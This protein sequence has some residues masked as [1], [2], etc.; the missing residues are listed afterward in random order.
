MIKDMVG[1]ARQHACNDIQHLHDLA[2]A[3]AA[4]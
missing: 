1:A 2:P 4:E 3:I